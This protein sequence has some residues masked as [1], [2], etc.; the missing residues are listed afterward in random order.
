MNGEFKVGQR[1]QVYQ[2][3]EETFCGGLFHEEKGVIIS[4]D[5]KSFPFDEGVGHTGDFDFVVK[6]DGWR[7]A[8]PFNAAELTPC[9]T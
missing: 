1:V 3:D 4:D 7:S 6:L 2:Y 8:F 9:T 5:V